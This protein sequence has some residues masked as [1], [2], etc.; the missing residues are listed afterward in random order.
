[1]KYSRQ[2][3][4]ILFLLVSITL[5]VA[6]TSDTQENVPADIEAKQTEI[7]LPIVEADN[8]DV[9]ESVVE[10]Q[11]YPD[12]EL[13]SESANPAYPEPESVIQP[14]LEEQNVQDED[15]PIE[16]VEPTQEP[17]PTSRGNQLVATDPSTVNLSSGNVQLVELFAFW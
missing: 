2:L 6:C 17:K 11:A 8:G 5:L 12:T 13:D 9:S 4:V 15:E 10:D 3:F 1:M 14:T 7:V 16:E